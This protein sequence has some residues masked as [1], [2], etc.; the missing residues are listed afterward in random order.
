MSNLNDQFFQ[1][2][3][4]YGREYEYSSRV[5]YLCFKEKLIRG[6]KYVQIVNCIKKIN[7]KITQK[8]N[9]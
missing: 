4:K 8:K 6:E 9:K 5:K 3:M 1:L 7:K 2:Y